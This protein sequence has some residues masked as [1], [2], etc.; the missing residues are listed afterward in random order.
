MPYKEKKTQHF[1]AGYTFTQELC[2][3]A[4]DF[5]LSWTKDGTFFAP[6]AYPNLESQEDMLCRGDFLHAI[7]VVSSEVSKGF[8]WSYSH[9]PVSLLE[10]TADEVLEI[11]TRQMVPPK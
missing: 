6:Y 7:T 3:W 4:E 10:T 9:Y 11:K 2:C 1:Q 8:L 5:L